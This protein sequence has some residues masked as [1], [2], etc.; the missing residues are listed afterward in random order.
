[1]MDQKDSSMPIVPQ[2]AASKQ[3][4]NGKKKEKSE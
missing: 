4:N 2:K 1:M 3:K